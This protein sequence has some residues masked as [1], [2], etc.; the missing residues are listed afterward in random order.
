MIECASSWQL[1]GKRRKKEEKKSNVSGLP[2]GFNYKLKQK[3]NMLSHL[4]ENIVDNYHSNKKE[5]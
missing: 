2:L 1:F 4:E 5:K 3:K